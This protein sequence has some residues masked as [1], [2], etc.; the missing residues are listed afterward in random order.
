VT[1]LV[2]DGVE[3][4]VLMLAEGVWGRRAMAVEERGR[5][6]SKYQRVSCRVLCWVRYADPSSDR[7]IEDGK[8]VE[9][10]RTDSHRPQSRGRGFG[11]HA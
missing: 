1:G 7:E 2:T 8:S 3:S 9:H 10:R 11:K 5:A 6:G 4:A